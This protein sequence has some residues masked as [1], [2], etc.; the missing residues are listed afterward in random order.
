MGHDQGS[1][2]VTISRW[3]DAAPAEAG[4]DL[5]ATEEPLEIRVGGQSVAVVMRTPGHDRELAAG[6][7]VTEGILRRAEDVLDMVYCRGD[8]AEPEANVLDVLLAPAAAI[9]LT[10]LTRHVFTSSSCGIC[11][12]ASIDAVRGQFPPIARPL[13]LRREVLAALPAR[14][15]AAQAAFARTGGLHAS[16]LFGSGGEP[17][18][19]R[20]DVGRHNALDKVIGRSF[21]DGRL[22][23]GD[24]ILLVSGRVSFEIMQ[25]ALAAGIPAVAAI[26]APTS[27]AVAFARASGQALVG[28]LRGTRMNVYAG[29]L[30]G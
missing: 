12:K 7:L 20:E 16:G 27:A 1:T 30:A 25:K 4:P 17:G 18:V 5:V 9:D 3:R 13:V 19:V 23:L 14:L 6:F 28:F 8:G 22:P 24:R 2:S 11:S 10:K 15:Q 29:T 26:S 21:L